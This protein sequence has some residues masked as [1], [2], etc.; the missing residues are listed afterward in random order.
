MA[1][2]LFSNTEELGLDL[3]VSA[4]V[5]EGKQAFVYEITDTKSKEKHY[6]WTIKTLSEYHSN[7]ILSRKMQVW[8]VKEVVSPKNLLIFTRNAKVVIMK[9]IYLNNGALTEWKIQDEFYKDVDA[10]KGKQMDALP[11]FGET[12][13]NEIWKLFNGD[14]YKQH[15]LI[16]LHDHTRFVFKSV[17]DD[18]VADLTIFQQP[19]KKLKVAGSPVVDRSRSQVHPGSIQSLS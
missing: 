1:M 9:D 2:F 18:S 11:N 7:G 13:Q 15:F 6:F 4:V 16:I 5:V 3:I 10:L 8:K 12:R 14:T 19:D 17:A